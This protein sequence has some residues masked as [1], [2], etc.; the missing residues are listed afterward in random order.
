MDSAEKNGPMYFNRVFRHGVD[1][2]R[3]VQVPAAWR[4]EQP[5]VE[6]TLVVWPKAKQGICLRVLLPEKMA[7]LVREIDALPNSDSGKGPLKR[8]IA[9]ESAQV[10]LGKAG[11]EGLA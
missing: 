5:G 9:R 10:N 6:L 11:R 8:F 7:E 2:K 4:P 3:R 1:E